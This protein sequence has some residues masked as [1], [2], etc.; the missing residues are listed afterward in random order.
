MTSAAFNEALHQLYRGDIL[1]ENWNRKDNQK[2]REG[3]QD[4]GSLFCVGNQ[5]LGY[6]SLQSLYV[7][8]VGRD[9]K[10]T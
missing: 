4:L 9:S 2:K 5:H 10:Q 1:N 8:N 3:S 6:I 7:G